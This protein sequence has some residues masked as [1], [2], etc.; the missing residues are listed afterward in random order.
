MPEIGFY[1][2]I[3]Y[4]QSFLR[5]PLEAFQAGGGK[6]SVVFLS[7]FG[8]ESGCGRL[9]R[10]CMED[11]GASSFQGSGNINLSLLFHV[12]TV[13][14]LPN[15][16][17]DSVFIKSSEF[18]PAHPLYERVLRIARGMQNVWEPC[19]REPSGAGNLQNGGDMRNMKERVDAE[20]PSNS[21][22]GRTA[23][24]TS[25]PI[26]GNSAQNRW[27]AS[28]RNIF[29]LWRANGRGVDVGRNFNANFSSFKKT[30]P[31]LAAPR[32]FCGDYPESE[33]ESLFFAD[34]VRKVRP[35][36]LVHIDVGKGFSLPAQ[37]EGPYLENLCAAHGILPLVPFDF[38]CT[39]EGWMAGEQNLHALRIGLPKEFLYENRLEKTYALLRPLILKLLVF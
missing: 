9:V 12:R 30:A 33:P 19:A 32:D 4:G 39:P 13:F 10:R 18:T 26:S 2:K 17:P 27:E 3:T 22:E 38:S 7:S 31:A 34:F 21:D 14:F 29:A 23:R 36:L 28:V 24:E 35:R 5:F 20:R 25:S 37:R 16:N 8:G 11:L 15:P 1:E 6:T